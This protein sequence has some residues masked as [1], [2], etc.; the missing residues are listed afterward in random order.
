MGEAS[1]FLKCVVE[2]VSKPLV[3]NV[4]ASCYEL[5]PCVYYTSQD[6]LKKVLLVDED[7][8][9]EINAVNVDPCTYTPS[10][11]LLNLAENYSHRAT[12]F[13]RRM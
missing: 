9:L 5:Q 8:I 1:F 3:L 7:N 11:V 13:W 4:T 2:R 10:T 12:I 6:G